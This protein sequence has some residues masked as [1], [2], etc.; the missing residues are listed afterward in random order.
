[1]V[2]GRL[3]PLGP[4]GYLPCTGK[5]GEMEPGG[6]VEGGGVDLSSLL[7]CHNLTENKNPG[8]SQR[9]TDTVM[10]ARDRAALVQF[11]YRGER[12]KVTFLEFM[13]DIC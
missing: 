4:L 11:L 8:H 2:V 1:M 12:I 5:N 13:S 6:A 9:A 3:G 10:S 7:Y